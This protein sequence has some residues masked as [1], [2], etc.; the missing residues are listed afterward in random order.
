MSAARGK[1]REGLSLAWRIGVQPWVVWAVTIFADLAYYD[2]QTDRALA[3]YGLAQRQSAFIRSF[4]Y[5]LDT[6]LAEWGIEPDAASTGLARGHLL[7]WDA[8]I[9][10]LL[11]M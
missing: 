2:G 4:Q 3:L 1:L 11:Q 8:T 9:R 5:D 7:D 10:T 6:R